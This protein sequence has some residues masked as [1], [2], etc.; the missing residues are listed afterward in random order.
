MVHIRLCININYI[1]VKIE[2][3]IFQ[4]I[5]NTFNVRKIVRYIDKFSLG[6]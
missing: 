5:P 2:K 3:D 6:R 4:I 1:I